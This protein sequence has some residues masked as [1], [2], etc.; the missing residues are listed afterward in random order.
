MNATTSHSTKKTSPI[1]VTIFWLYV[2][3]PLIWGVSSTMQKAMA[4]FH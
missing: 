2:S 4:L 3:I 1:V